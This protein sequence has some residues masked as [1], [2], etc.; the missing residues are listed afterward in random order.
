MGGMN[1]DPTPI[2]VRPAR[3]TDHPAI[4]ELS[5]RV[6]APYGPY[7]VVVPGWLVREDVEALVAERAG[8]FC[9]AVV[10]ARTVRDE[11]PIAELLA[12][13]VA[14]DQRRRGVG[15][16]LLIAALEQIK[17]WSGVPSRAVRLHTAADNQAARTLFTRFGFFEAD[18]VLGCYEGGQPIL[19]M[20]RPLN[21]RAGATPDRPPT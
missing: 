20:I 11:Q 3:H 18:D 17:R 15:T 2:Q 16:A 21:P 9:G 6:F 13:G 8:A 4:V 7:G 5:R 19:A 1:P 10:L 12:V 14:E